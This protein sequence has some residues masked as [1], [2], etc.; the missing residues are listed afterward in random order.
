MAQQV[1]APRREM[2]D[3]RFF[4]DWWEAYRRVYPPEPAWGPRA[5]WARVRRSAR[6]R[7]KAVLEGVDETVTG[8]CPGERASAFPDGCS[9]SSGYD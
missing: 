3:H 9:A 7:L 2:L 5:H 8:L 1:T 6:T 4:V